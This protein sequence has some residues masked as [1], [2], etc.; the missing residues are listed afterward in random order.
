MRRTSRFTPQL[1]ALDGYFSPT[2]CAGFRWAEASGIR[3]G[4]QGD[5]AE[6]FMVHSG[7]VQVFL[8]F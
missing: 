7:N 5:I 6:D 4:Y 1:C 2:I 3:V 8:E